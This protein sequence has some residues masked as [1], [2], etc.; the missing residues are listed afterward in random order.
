VSVFIASGLLLIIGSAYA[1]LLKRKLAETMFL[2]VVTVVFVLY[3]FG[4][5]NFSGSLLY[6]IYFIIGLSIISIVL[7][8]MK[9]RDNKTAMCDA[10][11]IKGVLIYTVLLALSLFMNYGRIF[12]LWDELWLWGRS[13]KHMYFVDGLNSV[14]HPNYAAPFSGYQPGTMLIQYFF[15]R[16][17]PKFV[18]Y[19]SYIAMNM[20]YF[21]MIMPF[22]KDIFSK[23]ELFIKQLLILFVLFIVPFISRTYNFSFYGTLYV[24]N[25]L[26]LLFGLSII[27]YYYFRYE[28][29]L[30]GILSVSAAVM[31]LTSTKDTGFL[32]AFGVAAIIAIDL[33]LFRRIKIVSYI[34]RWQSRAAKLLRIAFLFSPIISILFILL[35]W[36]SHNQR[37]GINT[38]INTEVSSLTLSDGFKIF[39]NQLEPYQMTVRENFTRALFDSQFLPFNQSVVLFGVIFI[40]IVFIF[41]FFYKKQ[42]YPRRVITASILLVVGLYAYQYFLLFSYMY[43]FWSWEAVRLASYSRYTYSYIQGMVIFLCMFFFFIRED[44]ILRSLKRLSEQRK[45]LK[46]D[47]LLELGKECIYIFLCMT[48]AVNLLMAVGYTVKTELTSRA[49]NLWYSAPR[50]ASVSVEKW[51]PYLVNEHFYII[52]QEGRGG[53]GH[54]LRLDLMPYLGLPA[55]GNYSI[56]NELYHGEDEPWTTIITPE[57][58]EQ[59]VIESR[60]TIVWVYQ[61][62]DVLKK[63]YGEFF[64]YGVQ[65]D[66]LYRVHI[67]EGR[68]SLVPVK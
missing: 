27:Y 29:S 56:S 8:F 13:V 41:A 30:Y 65:S 34:K 14:V 64:P 54:E 22:I 47:E 25:I 33:I 21:C 52:D 32:L 63:I 55:W 4:L 51:L 50:G 62:N 37:I 57:D 2:S 48:L 1:V 11:I 49:S 15:S 68:L 40:G 46:I 7:L 20:V 31:L 61:S 53:L 44:S 26:G 45:P 43:V 10:Q 5:L 16:F 19:K 3:C 23:K 28:E 24:D 38:V 42:I 60:F 36:A 58:W 9:Y 66:M 39:T 17:S 18:E 12:L 6:G 59:Y 35:S 67:D